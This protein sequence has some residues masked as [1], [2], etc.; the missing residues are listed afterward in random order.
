MGVGIQAKQCGWYGERIAVSYGL[1][2]TEFRG[3]PLDNWLTALTEGLATLGVTVYPEKVVEYLDV[4][5]D[6]CYSFELMN[7]PVIRREVWIR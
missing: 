6:E 5:E 1:Q 2:P 4:P 3:V 7:A